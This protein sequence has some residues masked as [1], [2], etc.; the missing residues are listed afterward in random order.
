MG[1]GVANYF[2]VLSPSNVNSFIDF[3]SMWFLTKVLKKELLK[4]PD[5]YRGIAVEGAIT[6]ALSGQS[7]V[8]AAT[9]TALQQYDESTADLDVDETK[10]TRASIPALI[11]LGIETLKPY[12]KLVGTQRKVWVEHGEFNATV[13]PWMGY[14]DFEFE[15]GVIVDLKVTKRAP[16]KLSGSHARQGAFYRAFCPNATRV[17]FVYLVALKREVKATILPL[18]DYENH[19]ED[20]RQGAVSMHAMLSISDDPQELV[21][22]FYPAPDEWWLS[23]EFS[24]NTAKEVWRFAS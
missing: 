17:D 22:L 13:L 24:R 8:G 4:S 7:D 2:K 15:G 9:A 12:G 21:P 18:E 1:S 5:M 14:I 20:L 16:S 6:L 23:D 11:A 3:R 19:L 10:E